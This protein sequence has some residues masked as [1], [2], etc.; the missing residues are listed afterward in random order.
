[1]VKKINV[2]ISDAL[3]ERAERWRGRF[4]PSELYQRALEDLV[5]KKEQLDE[6]VKGEP[7]A[8]EQ[9]IERLKSQKKEMEDNIRV[10]G[11]KMGVKWAMTADYWELQYAAEGFNPYGEPDAHKIGPPGTKLIPGDYSTKIHDSK[12]FADRVLGEYF[13][14]I[15]DDFEKKRSESPLWPAPDG[16]TGLKIMHDEHGEALFCRTGFIRPDGEEFIKGWL[17]G[18]K[19]FWEEVSPKLN[20]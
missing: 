9:I 6:R 12:I 20:D 5:S 1:M 18:V 8:M 19:A 4:S 15:N 10:M 16:G 14:G 7:E 2:S 11:Q 3:F 17:E 13:T